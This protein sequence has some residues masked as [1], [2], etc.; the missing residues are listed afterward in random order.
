VRV[1][2]R[3]G[4]DDAFACARVNRCGDPNVSR[5]RVSGATFVGRARESTRC[6]RPTCF[7]C[8]PRRMV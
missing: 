5:V 1:R 4:V 3:A 8:A 6:D 2:M 7:R